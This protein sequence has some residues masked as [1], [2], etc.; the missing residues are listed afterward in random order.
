MPRHVARASFLYLLL[1]IGVRR[2]KPARGPLERTLELQRLDVSL[3]NLR[4]LYLHVKRGGLLLELVDPRVDVSY[5]LVREVD[6]GP[7][8][9]PLDKIDEMQQSFS[10]L[11]HLLE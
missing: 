2:S 1:H 7:I 10:K 3:P 5:G 11:A 6:L 8:L 9:V 4:I